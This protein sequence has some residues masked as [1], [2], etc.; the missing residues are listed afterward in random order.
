MPVTTKAWLAWM[1]SGRRPIRV[2]LEL[3]SHESILGE[4]EASL[5]II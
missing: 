4:N 2:V 1:T 5:K 3:I